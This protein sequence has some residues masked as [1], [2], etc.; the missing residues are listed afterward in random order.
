MSDDVAKAEAIIGELEGKRTALTEA[1]AAHDAE[2]QR[3]AFAAHAQQDAEA[4]SAWVRWRLS[5]DR[6]RGATSSQ[7]LQ[8]PDSSARHSQPPA[9]GSA[10]ECEPQQEQN[11]RP[12]RARVRDDV[13]V[14]AS[15]RRIC[16]AF[17]HVGGFAAE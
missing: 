5:L 2:R 6:D 9:V 15:R 13:F 14:A 12:R 7:R 17:A 3:I 4:S 11:S 1:R 16:S 10:S 8:E